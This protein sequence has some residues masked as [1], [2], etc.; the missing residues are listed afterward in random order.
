MYDYNP[1]N[2]KGHTKT[3]CNSCTT[4]T[5]RLGLKQ[6]CVDYK[7]GRCERCGYDK[8]LRALSFHHVDKTNKDFGISGSHARSWEKIKQELD[9]CVLLC[10]NCHMEEHEKT[11]S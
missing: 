10:A 8:C 11:Y 4:N 5:R 2:T 3:N 9:K 6:K 7:G 1:K